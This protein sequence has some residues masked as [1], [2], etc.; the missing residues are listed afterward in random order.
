MEKVG[1]PNVSNNFY[2]A[3][4]LQEGKGGGFPESLLS[5]FLVVSYCQNNADCQITPNVSGLK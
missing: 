2:F 5:S 1:G 3:P 4:V